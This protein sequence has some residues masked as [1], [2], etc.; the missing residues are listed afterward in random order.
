M[1]LA[2]K[3]KKASLKSAAETFIFS[4]WNLKPYVRTSSSVLLLMGQALIDL[5]AAAK[6]S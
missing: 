5:L 2:L 1:E 3:M 4:L 6:Q